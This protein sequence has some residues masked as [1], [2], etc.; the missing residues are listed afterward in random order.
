MSCMRHLKVPISSGGGEP[1]GDDCKVRQ[2]FF[3]QAVGFSDPLSLHGRM[4]WFTALCGFVDLNAGSRPW[5]AFRLDATAF[6]ASM[7]LVDCNAA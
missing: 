5:L 3:E 2:L 6:T 7:A 1:G 4:R